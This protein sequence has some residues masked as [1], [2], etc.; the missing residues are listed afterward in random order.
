[1]ADSIC[2]AELCVCFLSFE[3][4]VLQK[5]Q[6]T[7]HHIGSFSRQMH[8]DGS[9]SDYIVYFGT[10]ELQT[11]FVYLCRVCSVSKS[12]LSRM[13]AH[14]NASVC[15]CVLCAN[16]FQSLLTCVSQ[17]QHQCHHTHKRT[18][19][20]SD[21]PTNQPPR[22][23][24]NHVNTLSAAQY[25]CILARNILQVYVCELSWFC[26][27]SLSRRCYAEFLFGFTRCASKTNDISIRASLLDILRW[28][29]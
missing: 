19:A 5:W 27:F 2:E 11:N 29:T 25:A 22:L 17:S 1:M 13:T 20:H 24:Q 14:V 10:S 18:H 16:M 21:Q 23:V 7:T 4:V 28:N 15:A 8:D 3:I 6:I 12:D 9:F 26:G